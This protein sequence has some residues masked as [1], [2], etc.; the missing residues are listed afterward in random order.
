MRFKRAISSFYNI[1]YIYLITLYKKQNRMKYILVS[2][3][4]ENW[5][6]DLSSSNER[7]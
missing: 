3:V 2:S 6:D 1:L 7:S 4:A 5:H